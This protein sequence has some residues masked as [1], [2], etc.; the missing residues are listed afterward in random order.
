MPFLPLDMLKSGAAELGIELTDRQLEQL[1]AFAEFMA[2]TNRSLNL[3]R[4]TEPG[5]IVT[6]HYLDCLTCLGALDVMPNAQVID[7]GTG[8][9]FPGIPIKIV[10]PD[11][12]VTLID[13]TFK[14]I[15]FLSDV[16]QRLGLKNIELLH[17]RAEAIAHEKGHRERYDVAYSRALAETTVLVEL[18]L[19]LVKVD[20]RMVAQKSTNVAEEVDAAKPI[21]G[22][23]GGRVEKTIRT[24]IP[25]TDIERQLVVIRKTKPTPV[26]FPRSY[27][28]MAGEKAR[29]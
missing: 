9:G 25:H 22:Q 1:D 3:T 17:A 4:I 24:R 16:V 6:G 2:E 11:L 18:C 12:R 15:K 5:E 28:R 26:Q 20:G 7:V 21:I 13:S 29:G 19:P 14:K 10:R 8:A 23:L 27:S